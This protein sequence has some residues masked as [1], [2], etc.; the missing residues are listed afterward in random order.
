MDYINFIKENK[1]KYTFGLVTSNLPKIV[2]IILKNLQIKEHFSFILTED[3]VKEVK[4]S[5]EPYLTALEKSGV[6]KD[7]A[8]VVE[9]TP[10]GI[11]SAKAADLKCI[12]LTTTFPREELSDA[13]IIQDKF[14]L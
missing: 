11:K 8:I 2:E 1:D 14:E 7:E 3:D 13:D 4:P 9:D 12:A 10:S 6:K 5:P